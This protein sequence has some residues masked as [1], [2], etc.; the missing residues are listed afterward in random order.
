MATSSI[1]RNFVISG[2]QHIQ[3]FANAIEEAQEKPSKNVKLNAVEVKGTE[4]LKKLL[5]KRKAK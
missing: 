5:A 3:A 2:T 4:N 1:N